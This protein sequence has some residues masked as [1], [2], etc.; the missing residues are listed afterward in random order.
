MLK[1]KELLERDY[2]TVKEV[3]E[4]LMLSRTTIEAHIRD[5]SLAAVKFGRVWRIRPKDVLAWGEA[6]RKGPDEEKEGEE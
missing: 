3:A 6:N 2:L 1:E 5:G 4:W